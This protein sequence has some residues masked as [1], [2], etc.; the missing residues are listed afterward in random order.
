MATAA[1]GIDPSQQQQ[2]G[3]MPGM[4]PAP[5]QPS[6]QE[7]N[8]SDP[9]QGKTDEPQ[10]SAGLQKDDQ[11]RL[12]NVIT[13]YKSQ[14]AQD[15]LI[16]MQRCLENIEFFK[17]NHFVSFNPGN[18]Q[19]FDVVS[20]YNENHAEDSDDTDL[21][22]YCNN[23][24][25]MLATAFVAALC[26]QVPKAEWLPEDADVP[27]DVA[28]AEAAQILI[29]IIERQNKVKSLLKQQLLYLYMCG[30]YFRHTRYIV[31]RDRAGT[32]EE[33]VFT[34]T[35]VEIQPDRYHCFR[36]GTDNPAANLAV[37]T[38]RRCEKCGAPLGDE[39]FYPS[40]TATVPTQTGTQQVANGMVA[41]TVY[42]P[43]EIDCDPAANSL[44]KTPILNLEVEVHVAAL[45]SS[46]PAMR[47]EITASASSPLSPNGSID[48]IARQQAYSQTGTA[49]TIM[50]DQKPTLSR[51]WIQP[52]AFDIDEDDKFGDRMRVLF[53]QGCLVIN[54][55]AT[56]L[57][58]KP[59]E[60]CAEWSWGKTHENFGIYPPA[61]GDV[62]IP[63]NK[64]FNDNASRIDEYMD[65]C[66]AGLT[67]ANSRLIDSKAMNGK[68]LLPGVLNP[69]QFRQT[70]VGQTFADALFQF[71]FSMDPEAFAYNDKL[72]YYAQ[73]FAGVPPQVYGGAG[74][75]HIETFGGQQQQLNT[76][77][78]KLNIYWENLREESAKA[79]ELAVRC[80]QDNM[81]DDVKQVVRERG[82]EFR[83]NYVRLQDIRGS[84]HAFP[85]TD[86][87]FPITA[88]ELRQRWMDLMD[89][90]EKN[91]VTQA[92]FDEPSNQRQAATALG[93][94]NM[95]IPGS[96]MESKV[97]QIIEKLQ[98]MRPLP[99][100]DPQTGKIAVDPQTGQ[101]QMKPAIMPEKDIDDFDVLRKEVRQYCQKNFDLKDSN[102]Q[103][104][105]HIL[106]YLQYAVQMQTAKLAEAA[107]NQATVAKAGMPQPPQPDPAVQQAQQLILK[108]G[109]E[110]VGDLV[111]IAG[112]PPL[113][114]G[115][116]L[117]AQVAAAKVVVDAALSAAGGK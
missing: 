105:G 61:I 18:F 4:Q 82:S 109:A 30:S 91:P 102:P 13:R 62:V 70:G 89:A 68:P 40:V 63:F 29:D 87:G 93:V 8:P 60:L 77:L 80:S 99:V 14:W 1:L 66:S 84:V 53:P 83:N 9:M 101:P 78:G 86:Q 54:C 71:K 11:S 17:G 43:L 75:K 96:A 57:E 69:V 2:P 110:T 65:R 41:W 21:Y 59:A 35:E 88:A 58:A 48:R 15:R 72:L 79:D 37:M 74:D 56:F 64:R 19:F 23:M 92:I 42:S 44:E 103:G 28:T 38:S 117:Q 34:D 100:V 112:T 26:P 107:Q 106:L 20:W 51:T 94:P 52:W 95:V 46:Y 49:S 73:M 67:L 10:N 33:P 47:K 12:I 31:D 16:L 39:S 3:A 27:A 97:L 108:D 24:Y 32:H 81:T 25:Q 116:S 45:R 85:D 114:K 104:Y 98:K 111:K 113:P 22:K 50:Q 76:A 6:G 90:A 55:G 115:S 36:C 5:S 7:H